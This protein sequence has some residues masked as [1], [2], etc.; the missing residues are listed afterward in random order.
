MHL[1]KFEWV[2]KNVETGSMYKPSTR[3][4]VQAV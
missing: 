3:R 1:S 4:E 2:D